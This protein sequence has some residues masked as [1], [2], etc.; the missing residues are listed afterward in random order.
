MSSFA[1][2]RYQKGAA[3][4]DENKQGTAIYS[5]QPYKYHEWAFKTRM[6]F[7]S[8]K[9][10]EIPYCM[11][12]VVEGLRGE[13]MTVATTLGAATLLGDGGVEYLIEAMKQ[14]VFP[15]ARAEAR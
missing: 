6:R 7:A 9:K 2:L 4:L 1:S 3:P 14:R 5:G 8:A 15:L 12:K 10:G 13:A 11:A